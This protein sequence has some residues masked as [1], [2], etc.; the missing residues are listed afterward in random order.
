M[1]KNLNQIRLTWRWEQQ[2][3]N[4]KQFRPK[5]HELTPS[6]SDAR[7]TLCGMTAHTTRLQS[8]ISFSN[9]AW[10]VHSVQTCLSS[11]ILCRQHISRAVLEAVCF[12]VSPRFTKNKMG[13]FYK[14][15]H[16]EQK[17][18]LKYSFFSSRPFLQS[19]FQS[20]QAW[21]QSLERHFEK[22]LR[23][24]RSF[25]PW[26]LTPDVNPSSFWWMEVCCLQPERPTSPF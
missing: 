5:T 14:F 22:A 3:L 4:I 7:G 16:K 8:K 15:I 26:W 18:L 17:R 19:S 10:N 6:R 11:T 23:L 12:Q 21:P 1:N 24:P 20:A 13:L 9:V 2:Q 25:V